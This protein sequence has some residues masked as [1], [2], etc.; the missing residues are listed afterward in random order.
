MS[1]LSENKQHPP[2]F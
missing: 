1:A 2:K